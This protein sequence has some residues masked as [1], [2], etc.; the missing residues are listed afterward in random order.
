LRSLHQAHCKGLVLKLYKIQLF[1]I[2]IFKNPGF[3]LLTMKIIGFNLSKI[4]CE[5]KDKGPE[6]LQ[7]N[8]NIDIK[9]VIKD[10][11]PISQGEILIVKFNFTINYSEDFAKVEFEGSVI[12]AP[13]KEELKEFLKSWKDKKIPEE[14]RMPLFNFIMAK[15]NIKALTLEDDLNLP[16]HLPLPR[17]TPQNNQ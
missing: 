8:Q 13:E 10:K 6:K 9:E 12:I 11:I 14:L 2:I 3:Y 7:I 17:I 1:I 5:K 16:P 15:C 4:L